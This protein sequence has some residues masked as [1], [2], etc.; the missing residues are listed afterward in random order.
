[1][2]KTAPKSIAKPT[3]SQPT[4][5]VYNFEVKEVVAPYLKNITSTSLLC[6]ALKRGRKVITSREVQPQAVLSTPGLWSAEFNESLS[7]ATNLFRD[8]SGVFL[9]KKAK[10]EVRCKGKSLFVGDA[11]KSIG[12]ATIQLDTIA[13]T[14]GKAFQGGVIG[15]P[16][17]KCAM[18]GATLYVRITA[19][20]VGEGGGGVGDETQSVASSIS[21]MESVD[22]NRREGQEDVW[23][24]MPEGVGSV[25][26]KSLEERKSTTTSPR[27]TPTRAVIA[28]ELPAAKQTY[29]KPP[30][31]SSLLDDDIIR[32][33]SVRTEI[34]LL[35]EMDAMRMEVLDANKRASELSIALAQTEH[36]LRQKTEEEMSQRKRADELQSKFQETDVVRKELESEMVVRSSEIL[37]LQRKLVEA[38]KS[39]KTLSTELLEKGRTTETLLTDLNE[40]K[41][42]LPQTEARVMAWRND[43]I[44]QRESMARKHALTLAD[45]DQEINTLK[46]EVVRVSSLL[47]LL[48]TSSSKI[49][50]ELIEVQKEETYTG[51]RANE[52]MKESPVQL[53]LTEKTTSE[54]EKRARTKT[55]RFRE[56]KEDMHVK[57]LNV[58]EQLD[59]KSR[60]IE[61]LE[62][63]LE[64]ATIAMS[65]KV[66]STET[67]QAPEGEDD[68]TFPAEKLFIYKGGD[69]YF[70]GD[71]DELR[72][73][74]HQ[75][76]PKL[77]E[78][79]D[80]I[81]ILNNETKHVK[82]ENVTMSLKLEAATSQVCEL[83]TRLHEQHLQLQSTKDE[84]TRCT[85]LASAV[86]VQM[87]NEKIRR[88]ESEDGYNRMLRHV[89]EVIEDMSQFVDLNDYNDDLELGLRKSVTAIIV[90]LKESTDGSREQAQRLRILEEKLSLAVASET[91]A[92]QS[93]HDLYRVVSGE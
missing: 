81:S 37:D 22:D 11:F 45:R 47:L 3:G 54:V 42:Q 72:S 69:S 75:L 27:S 67:Q 8:P 41:I 87:E 50:E 51:H 88:M 77:Y 38:M 29:A 2:H 52:E 4:R 82:E 89:R 7:V 12:E 34:A 61:G 91:L 31:L 1:M 56:D 66:N 49:E 9:D 16:L 14:L 44:A 23:W 32:S 92:K 83:Q 28:G 85:T 70:N 13:C 53:L 36:D 71:S 84:L 18:E 30:S 73:Q 62:S 20:A 17:T 26:M 78:S 79:D 57:Y 5:I 80:L 46:A 33:T 15:L 19:T 86:S 24:T 6:I 39:C 21:E 63:E 65:A 43:Q 90:Q 60:M 40:I 68:V 76:K 64:A 59:G 10:L 58:C 25:G 74:L 55:R 48:E 93:Y 35:S